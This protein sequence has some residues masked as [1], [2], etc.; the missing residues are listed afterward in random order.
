MYFHLKQISLQLSSQYCVKVYK[1]AYKLS[2]GWSDMY[3]LLQISSTDKMSEQVHLHVVTPQVME[4]T[5]LTVVT[6]MTVVNI[7]TKEIVMNMVMIDSTWEGHKSH[8]ST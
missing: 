7:L 5:L 1:P 2:Y 8:N 4:V 6:V 3:A